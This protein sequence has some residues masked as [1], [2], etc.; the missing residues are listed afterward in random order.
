MNDV[1]RIR[2]QSKQ[3]TPC[4]QPKHAG[5]ILTD[6]A[7]IAP[8]FTGVDPIVSEG[9][10]N[11]VEPIQKLIAAHPERSR[12]ILEQ[13]VDENTALAVLASRIMCE[14]SEFIAV[15]SVETILSPE[16]DESLIVL[17]DLSNLGLGQSLSGR[18]PGESNIVAIDCWNS[19]GALA[20][21]TYF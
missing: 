7:N 11:T 9:F 12:T 2:V 1:T 15:V 14:H 17:Y 16:P 19:H 6:F 21:T 20:A 4:C 13:R 3:A 8:N 5:P 10:V 18:Q